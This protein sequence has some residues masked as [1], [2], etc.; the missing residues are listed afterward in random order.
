MSERRTTDGVHAPIRLLRIAAIYA[1]LAALWV[2]LSSFT[3]SL[4][5][6][7]S[8]QSEFVVEI[9]KGLGFVLATGGLLFLILL[10]LRRR[11]QS[12]QNSLD[13]SRQ[14]SEAERRR[15]ERIARIGHWVWRPA[16]GDFDWAGG[17]SEYSEAAAA[18]F[19]VSP[20]EL[21][22]ST[23]EYVDRFVHPDDRLR[24]ARYFSDPEHGAPGM[25]VAE[26]R[27]LRP[28]GEIR[29]IYEATEIVGDI[30]DGTR[31]WQ[32]T[33]Q[34]VTE[35][36]R[37]EA[38]L[39][40]SEARF[41]DFAGVASQF[42]WELDENHRIVAYSGQPCE[43]L[44]RSS[45]EI[46]GRTFHE[47]DGI[48]AG[49]SDSDWAAFEAL[50]AARQPFQDFPYAARLESGHTEYR[51]ASARPIFD[52]SGT[53]KG[54]R[55]VTRD[56]TRE[57]E[58]RRRAQ[59][60]EE[61]LTR[62]V[63]SI[64]DGF[65]IYD[66]SDRLVMMNSK[67][68]ESFARMGP[69][70]PTGKTFEELVRADIAL[71]YYP[72]AAGREE[73]FVTERL[74]A[75]RRGHV[76]IFR[77]S[78]GRW[79]QARDQ[80]LPDGSTVAIRTDVTELAERDQALRE[81]QANLVA[82]QRIAKMGSWEYQLD[83]LENLDA[84]PLRWSDETYAIFGIEP[85]S[86]IAGADFFRRVPEE[87][88]A[89]IREAVRR[90]IAEGLPYDVEHRVVKPDGHE[91]IVHDMGEVIADPLTGRPLK[92]VGTIQD[93]TALKRAQEALRQAQKMEA[94]GQLTGGIAHDFNNLLM[95]VGGNLELLAEGLNPDQQR[96]NRFA[97]A[98]L[99]A[100][101]RGSKLTERLLAFAR[102]QKLRSEPTDLNRLIGNLVPLLHRTLGEQIVVETALAGDI[103]LTMTDGS[104]VENAVLNLAVN[105][106]D[107]MPEGGRLII[108][109][110]NIHLERAQARGSDD[111]QPGDYV[112][113]SVSDNGQGMPADV[114]E[115]AFEPFFT[116]KSAG[117]G[118][119]LGLSMVYGFVKQSGGHVRILSEV[120]RG[121]TVQILL[122][123]VS[124][125]AVKTALGEP[126][127]LP[128]GHERIL[129]VED[130]ELVR[131]TVRVMLQSLGYDISEAA[132][133]RQ[134]LALL[135]AGPPF[136]LVLTDM[137]MPGGMS[138][139]D[140]A[141]AIWRDM[142]QQR[143]LFSTGYSDNPIFHQAHLD[144]RIQVL[145]KP[146]SKQI[147]ATSLRAAIAR[148]MP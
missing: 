108:R 141:Q 13:D 132:D 43:L 144:E 105:A 50:L 75:H 15:I 32:G 20:R 120:A 112:Q 5:L 70:D 6:A 104:Q 47:L 73:A 10:R 38:D 28:D 124:A 145:P 130:E 21:A 98:A 25:A 41:R 74:L 7:R 56:E 107:A 17:S 97:T 12:A 65:A 143:F 29:T 31:Y 26:Y 52:A 137:V 103:G 142:P 3:D 136:D 129:L 101:S 11:L 121:T 113:L 116:T 133:G 23:R 16:A 118:T 87:D 67:F 40:L 72:E 80:A 24:V 44:P 2:A 95:V 37:I 99:E 134:A 93:V 79:I 86:A 60:A 94:I 69:G 62:A 51:R 71:G 126:A 42:Q 33:V 53:F 83:D 111:L 140:L 81:S 102:R 39:A 61:L 123:R 110:E 78:Q 106:R 90:S 122:P 92:M 82:A 85:T 63:E 22:I 109:T 18:I 125:A 147:L 84:N 148:P 117:R 131:S 114:K 88:H 58:A 96:L 135:G 19:G 45:G 115:R 89:L 9:I 55:G 30:A 146:Y 59:A 91:I 34:D 77:N 127:G 35:I 68:R 66:A 100:V 54:Y 27:I 1:A 49:I 14:Q 48:N 64:S 76:M 128:R 36:R 138:G 4:V 46:L 119:G 57:V 8:P 139:W